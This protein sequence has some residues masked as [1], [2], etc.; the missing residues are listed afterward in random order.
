LDSFQNTY[1]DLEKIPI[2]SGLYYF[3][4][5]DE[6]LLYIGKSVRL[7]SRV[8]QHRF[9]NDYHREL[10]YYRIMEMSKTKEQSAILER[11]IFR[12]SHR[13]MLMLSPLVID[14]IFHRTKRIEIEEIPVELIKSRESEVIFERRPLFNHETACDEYYKMAAIPFIDIDELPEDVQYM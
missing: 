2:T 10:R 5:S 4:D 7:K 14:W 13:L 9:L 8:E 12:V 1:D 6:N 11:N 3:Y